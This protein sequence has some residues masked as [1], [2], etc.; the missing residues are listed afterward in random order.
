MFHR[1]RPVRTAGGPQRDTER[2]RLAWLPPS[3]RLLF[4]VSEAQMHRPQTSSVRQWHAGPA[5]GLRVTPLPGLNAASRRSVART[6][7]IAAD[8]G[9]SDAGESRIIMHTQVGSYFG[10]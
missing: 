1:D 5:A 9:V 6:N 10:L 3:G 7:L 2:R 4:A 8:A